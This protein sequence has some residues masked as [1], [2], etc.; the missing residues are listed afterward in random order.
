MIKEAFDDDEE[1]ERKSPVKSKKPAKIS[2]ESEDKKQPT[3]KQKLSSE[4]NSEEILPSIFKN[5]KFFITK[6]V[7]DIEKLKRYIKT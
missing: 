5:K 1:D 4:V 3:K 2:K 6:K 7:K